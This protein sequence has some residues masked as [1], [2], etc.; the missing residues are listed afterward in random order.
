MHGGI[1][2]NRDTVPA[3]PSRVRAHGQT[4]VKGP[5]PSPSNRRFTF[6]IRMRRGTGRDGWGSWGVYY[7]TNTHNSLAMCR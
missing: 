1:A 4:P 6:R 3:Y 5:C 7:K 2:M